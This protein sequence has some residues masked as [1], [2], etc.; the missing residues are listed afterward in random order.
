MHMHGELSAS[1]LIIQLH[2]SS[3]LN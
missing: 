2:S 3:K 1:S